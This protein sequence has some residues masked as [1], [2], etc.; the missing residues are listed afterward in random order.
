[1]SKMGIVAA[2]TCV[3][4]ACVWAHAAPLDAPAKTAF[5]T[6]WT[7]IWWNASESG[8]GMQLVQEGSTVFATVFFY[9]SDNKPTWIIATLTNTSNTLN[10]PVFVTTGPFYGAARFDTSAVT[11]RQAGTMTI[12]FSDVSTGRLS[13][14]VDGVTVNKN[15]VRQTIA[16]DDYSGTYLLAVNITQGNC[17]NPANNTSVNGTIGASVTHNGTSMSMSWQYGGNVV[18]TYSGTYTQQGRFGQLT[19]PY[20]CTDNDRG[21]MT[22]FELTNR[23]GMMSGRLTGQSTPFGCSYSGRFSGVDPNVP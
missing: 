4:V 19:G 15:I 16:A 18:C 2:A 21:T 13:Y 3:A 14:T 22:F 7:D 8:W 1:M 20:T 6:D 5:S 9:G 17:T 12:T 11:I 10:G 23:V